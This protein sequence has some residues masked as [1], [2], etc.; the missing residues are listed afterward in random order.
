MVPFSSPH[1]HEEAVPV[2]HVPERVLVPEVR[3]VQVTPSVE[4]RMVP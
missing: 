1:R 2:G 4:V 3:R